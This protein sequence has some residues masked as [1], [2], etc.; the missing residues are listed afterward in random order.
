MKNKTNAKK[1]KKKSKFYPGH[2]LPFI[3][4]MDRWIVPL[5]F[6]FMIATLV[7]NAMKIEGAAKFITLSYPLN[8]NMFAKGSNDVYFVLFSFCA[9][10]VARKIISKCVF[11]P[12]SAILNVRHT[13]KFVEQGWLIVYYTCSF[14]VGCH[15]LALRNWDIVEMMRTEVP[16]LYLTGTEKAFY[17]IQLSYW[18]HA[19]PITLIEKWRADFIQMIL[20][21]V[22]TIGMISISYYTN[23]TTFGLMI[24]ACSDIADIF[25]PLAKLFKY[26]NLQTLADITF[27]IFAIVWIPTRHG[28]YMQILYHIVFSWYGVIPEAGTYDPSRGVYLSQNIHLT[29]IL[30]LSLF[31]LL[32]CFWLRLLIISIY[33]AIVNQGIDDSRSDSESD[34]EEEDEKMKKDK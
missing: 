29:W 32:L 2:K 7:A 18:F 34:E 25:L 28:F 27:A 12:V 21:H 3:R 22:F 9:L 23:M 31:Q 20:H 8:G 16:R 11:E 15:L 14:S 30:V 10:T 4:T 6:S 33:K 26:A 24:L 13:R 5:T 19:V 1:E 17:L